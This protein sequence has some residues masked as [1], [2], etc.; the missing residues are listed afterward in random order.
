MKISQSEAVAFRNCQKLHDFRYNQGLVPRKKVGD[1]AYRGTIAHKGFEIFYK[2]I[3]EHGWQSYKEAA[4]IAIQKITE[5]MAGD[6]FNAQWYADALVILKN[7]FEY[8]QTDKNKYNV[9]SAEDEFEFKVSGN[10]KMGLRID[11]LVEYVE[12]PLAGK[13]MLRDFKS[14]YDFWPEH[15]QEFNVQFPVYMYVLNKLFSY[16][17]EYMELQ[18]LRTRKLKDPTFGDLF[19]RNHLHFGFTQQEQMWNEFVTTATEIKH[20]RTNPEIS[21]IPVRNPDFEWCKKCVFTSPCRLQM[22]GRHKDAQDVIELEFTT[23]DSYS[24]GEK[25]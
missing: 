25:F 12:G 19:E 21:P 7:Y 23:N 16:N 2:H 24:Y 4:S 13:I 17:M 8:Y 3:Q 18:Q 10:L 9:V 22:F 15:K 14:T 20:R 11:L 6:V 1:A 5:M